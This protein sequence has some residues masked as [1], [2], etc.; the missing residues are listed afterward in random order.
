[1]RRRTAKCRVVRVKKSQ[2]NRRHYG[3]QQQQHQQLQQ[4][5]R[6]QPPQALPHRPQ[7][8]HQH[9]AVPHRPRVQHQHQAVPHRLQVQLRQQ[10]AR[11][12]QQVQH[13]LLLHHQHRVQAHRQLAYVTTVAITSNACTSGWKGATILY[14]CDNCPDIMPYAQYAY[15][16][17]AIVNRTRIAFAFREDNGC[18]ALDTITVRSLS[19]PGIELTAN[20]DFETSD[21]TSWTYCN[22]NGASSAG[23]VT[24]NSDNFLCINAILQAHTGNYFYYDGAVT[25][26]DYLFQTFATTVGAAYNISYWLF[27]EGSSSPSSADVIISV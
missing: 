8:P 25:N 26:C 9:R 2:R 23:A 24:S 1:M 7:V 3:L 22:P 5:Q 27:N 6:R 17:T 20:G 18:F 13:Q 12:H 19:A 21:L 4:H 16:Y 15:T 11:H 10:A 14:H